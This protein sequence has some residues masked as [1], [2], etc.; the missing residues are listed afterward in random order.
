MDS[1]L[2]TIDSEAEWN[3]TLG[4]IRYRYYTRDYW[5]GLTDIGVEGTWVW[6]NGGKEPTGTYHWLAGAPDNSGGSEHCAR[7][8]R[9]NGYQDASCDGAIYYICEDDLYISDAPR[10]IQTTIQSTTSA[11]ITWTTPLQMD[12]QNA[13]LIGY[14]FYYWI[15]NKQS[16]TTQSVTISSPDTFELVFDSLSP[17]TTYEFYMTGYN[18]YGEGVASDPPGNFTTVSA[19]LRSENYALNIYRIAKGVYLQSHVIFSTE[20][21]TL[22]HC[23]NICTGVLS[24]Q[25]VNFHHKATTRAKTCE[26]NEGTRESYSSDVV[27]DSDYIYAGL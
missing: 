22:Q 24:C 21:I 3:Y 15:R 13:D 12:S 10:S 8:D 26:I 19:Q 2:I 14:K 1:D 16:E 11:V 4:Y 17:G 18:S 6:E 25:S 27:S 20:A 5:V 9:Y 7:L 23:T